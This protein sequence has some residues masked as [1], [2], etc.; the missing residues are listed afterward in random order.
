MKLIFV[1]S[2]G[3]FALLVREDRFHERARILFQ[4]ANSE[5]QHLVTTNAVVIETYALLLTR[6]YNG[7]QN[8][9]AFLDMIA[10]D[11]YQIE[12]ICATDEDAAIRLVRSHQDKSYSLCDA[13]SFM[14]MERLGIHEAIAF[15]R[16]FHEYGRFTIL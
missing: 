14:V 10:S 4:R 11:A 16:H 6:T 2:G 12:R 9:I 1:D 15:D 8:V 5:R 13:L 7:R 3:F